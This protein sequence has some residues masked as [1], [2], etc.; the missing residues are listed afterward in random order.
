VKDPNINNDIRRICREKLENIQRIT[1]AYLALA[2]CDD[3][4]RHNQV[5]SIV[6]QEVSMKCGLSNGPPMVYLQT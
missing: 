5:A 2:K 3:T 4:H 1:G 6:R